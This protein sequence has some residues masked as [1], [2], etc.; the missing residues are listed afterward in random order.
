MDHAQVKKM[1]DSISRA[2]VSAL[3]YSMAAVLMGS[4]CVV[5]VF[6]ASEGAIPRTPFAAL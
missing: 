6:L 3:L 2:F 4:M 5:L 1:L